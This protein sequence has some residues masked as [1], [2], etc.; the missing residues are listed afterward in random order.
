MANVDMR[1]KIVG[2]ILNLWNEDNAAAR[3]AFAEK[4]IAPDFNY[5]DPHLKSPATSRQAFLDF[6]SAFRSSLP[7]A[8]VKLEGTPLAH[9]D[10]AMIR[11][12]LARGGTPFSKGVF[13]LTFGPDDRLAQMVGFVDS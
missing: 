2:E 13:F 5:A 10:Y 1:Q 11:F 7:D 8:D 6:L 12:A 3:A 9:H 4:W